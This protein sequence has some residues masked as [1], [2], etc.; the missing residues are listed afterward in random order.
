MAPKCPN[1]ASTVLA[2]LAVVATAGLS[3]S[4][5]ASATHSAI[6]QRR[7]H[8]NVGATHSPR[9]ER[10]LAGGGARR[11]ARPLAPAKGSVLG[12]DVASGQHAG[13]AM[14]DWPQVAAAGYRFAFVKTTEGSYY[15]NPFFSSDLAGAKAAG[16]LVAAYHFAN[17]ADSS[18]TFQA[19][20]AIDHAGLGS[21]GA[22]LP[23]IADLEFDPYSANEC[24]GLTPRQ[25]VSWITA[26]TAEVDRLTGQHPVIYT[27]ADWWDKCTG[28]STAF[29][30]D[31]LWVASYDTGTMG[32]T[33]PVGWANWTYWQ[34]T[35]VGKVP[36][37]KGDTD[38]SALSPTALEVAQP[39]AQSDQPGATV[40]LP[41]R[42]VNA[43]AGQPLSYTAAGLPSGLAID[44]SSGLITG[45]VP[46]AIASSAASVTVSGTGLHPVTVS[47]TWNLHGA[48]ALTRPN[49]RFG[50]V[51]SPR[52]LEIRAS[53]GLPGCTLVFHASGLPAG[54][55]MS[56]CGQISG[57]LTKP[58][59]YHVTVS[60]TDST[61][62]QLAAT[63]FGWQVSQPRW[64]GPAGHITNEGSCLIRLRASVSVGKCQHIA[65]ERWS[66]SSNGELR[67]GVT[68]LAAGEAGPVLLRPCRGTIFQNW[69][70]GTDGALINLATGDCLTAV[71]VNHRPAAA[72][73]FG[74]AGTPAQRWV[75]PPE[76]IT[77]GLPGWCASA[78]PA[79]QHS[80]SLS[81]C[82][83]AGRWIAGPLGAL[84]AAGQCLT[85]TSPAV[86]GSPVRMERCDGAPA[87]RWQFFN[88]LAGVQLVSPKPGLCLADP[89]DSRTVP[90]KL[91][92]GYCLVTDPGVSWRFG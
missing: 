59:S 55:T 75:L 47:F 11:A 61:G 86:A 60:V 33:M 23:L 5:A 69:Q 54:L 20:F 13:G 9:L 41:I 1:R 72:G 42:S 39:A 10:L 77:S 40:S 84:R 82:P 91:K 66:I 12:I 92:L 28:D 37:I 24:Y 48:V 62:S 67:Q 38:L 26:F 16:L 81:R 89:G 4:A 3:S 36:G 29:T 15:A 53:D 45:T 64:T 68:C 80:V 6:I 35:S 25:M 79:G 71:T 46:A 58:G 74:C 21:D 88:A 76:P 44:P 83:L 65:S 19:D 78:P 90:V 27:I 34:Y 70:A 17:P 2:L 56:P 8:F 43:S 18:G 57:W 50:P 32:P 51:G 63:S 85:I 7:G 49:D 73:V 30:A 31:P 14:I 52:L 22:T 87:Q